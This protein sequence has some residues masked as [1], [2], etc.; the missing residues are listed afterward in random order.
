MIGQRWRF[1]G[2]TAERGDLRLDCTR[3]HTLDKVLHAKGENDQ[4][5]YRRK[6]VTGCLR[7]NIRP[8]GKFIDL[9]RIGGQRHQE[10]LLV[11]AEHQ[12]RPDIIAIDTNKVEYGD[13]DEDRHRQGD[14]D[15]HQ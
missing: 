1:A 9:G 15:A 10:G 14:R 7:A 12:R 8:V 2:P 11:L 6:C 4:L 5:R 3:R 13:G